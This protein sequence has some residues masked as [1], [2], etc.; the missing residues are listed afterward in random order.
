MRLTLKTAFDPPPKR[1]NGGKELKELKLGKKKDVGGG[2]TA[3]AGGKKE[4]G[5][6]LK[7]MFPVS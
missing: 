4:R 7:R 5:S 6:A 3:G 2:G 1:V